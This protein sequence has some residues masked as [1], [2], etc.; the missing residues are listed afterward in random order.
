MYSVSR[1]AS[2]GQ[3]PTMV[4]KSSSDMV[5][6]GIPRGRP[7]RGSPAS[8]GVRTGQ[9]VGDLGEQVEARPHVLAALA[10]VGGGG[11]QG[12]RPPPLPL[13]VGDVE[14]RHADG[15]VPWRRTDLAGGAQHRE[16]VEGRVL[17]P[18]GLH[19]GADLLKA[20]HEVV[21]QPGITGLQQE[22]PHQLKGFGVAAAGTRAAEGGADPRPVGG[23][24][25][26]VGSVD[27]GPVD[28]QAQQV[29]DHP[30]A[31]PVGRARQ[32]LPGP[33]AA[34]RAEHAHQPVDVGPERSVH[35]L[36]LG[37]P[38]DLLEVVGVPGGLGP[39]LA[40][41]H[42]ARRVDEQAAGEGAELVAG[43]AV[44][45]PGVGQRLVVG[46]DL[47]D[48]EPAI[49]VPPAHP[50][51]VGPGL[52]QAVDVVD[53]DR[54]HV[55]TIQQRVDHHVGGI[56]HLGVLDPDPDQR[57]DVEEVAVVRHPWSPRASRPVRSAVR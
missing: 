6:P 52:A 28:V 5:R 40:E 34:D 45:R 29:L 1:P 16:A 3:A 24:G 53:P 43:G 47:L 13:A 32:L 31:Q 39:A 27:V 10:V 33:V 25:L 7:R 38:G 2:I 36:E 26:G 56:Q 21:L 9:A 41:R 30:G 11:Q 54:V 35:H 17:D 57:R 15:R 18:L 22:G 51:Q 20:Q 19:H 4:W 55:A 44:D 46:E 23:I 8:G 48:P 37:V 12:A 14:L 42:P 49:G 50:L